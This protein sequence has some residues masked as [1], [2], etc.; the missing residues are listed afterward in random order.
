MRPVGTA[1]V[2]GGLF[3]TPGKSAASTGF[4]SRLAAADAASATR[5]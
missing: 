1:A 2:K 3:T 5:T 4:F